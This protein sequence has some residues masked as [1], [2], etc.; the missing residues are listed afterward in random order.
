MT[1]I[2]GMTYKGKVYIGADSLS[3]DGFTKEVRKE[4]KVFENGEFLIGGTTSFRMLNLLEWKFNPP[5]VK[6]GDN[7][8]KF[9]CIDFVDAVRDLFITNGFCITTEDWRNG[10]FL[11]GIKGRLFK[12]ECDFQVAEY[13]YTACGS[14]EYHALGCLYTSKKDK[15]VKNLVKALE[16]A[17]NFVTSVQR[18]FIVKVK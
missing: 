1:C 11:V 2:V 14:G 9:M 6:D 13:D 12:L 4:H 7:L 16:C 18:P 3:S 17:E 15:P 5:T 8:H 10:E